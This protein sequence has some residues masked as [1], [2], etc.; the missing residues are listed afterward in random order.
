MHKIIVLIV[1]V[2]LAIP[3]FALIL[4]QPRLDRDWSPDQEV[5]AT[6][7]VSG[8]DITIHNIRHFTYR[9]TT[10]YTPNYYDKT[11]DLSTIKQ[12]WYVVEPFSPVTGPAHTFVSFEFEGDQFVAISIEVRKTKGDT[13]KFLKSMYHGYELMYV[14]ADE[15]DVIKLRAVDRKDQ[16]FLYPVKA[17][18]EELRAL[19]LDMVNEANTLTRRPEFYNLFTNSC[20]TKI[21]DHINDI[22]L[23]HVPLSWK[24]ILPAYSDQLALELGFLDTDLPIDQARQK[25][26]INALAEQYANDPQFSLRIRGR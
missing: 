17:S 15:R 23:R 13:F 1:L 26:Q 24:Y 16:V 14:I 6:A 12:A 19:F 3:L 8:D 20:T 9:S 18:K 10:D 25:Y 22:D 7:D 11:F 5:L 4:K 21:V 2:L